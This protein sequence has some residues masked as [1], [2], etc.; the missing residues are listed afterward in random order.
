MEVNDGPLSS[1]IVDCHNRDFAIALQ[2]GKCCSFEAWARAL[3]RL[4]MCA[5]PIFRRG[6]VP[7]DPGQPG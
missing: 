2:S 3:M 7:N 1:R 5:G 4:E 6:S